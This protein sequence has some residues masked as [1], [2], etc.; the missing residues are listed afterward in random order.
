M[1]VIT[2]PC[3]TEFSVEAINW[4]HFR[5]TIDEAVHW[6]CKQ[7][8]TNMCMAWI[9]FQKAYVMVLKFLKCLQMFGVAKNVISFMQIS[10]LSRMTK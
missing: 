10:M 6:K 1:L 4:H 7:W 5:P 9:D 2:I 8:W 3:M